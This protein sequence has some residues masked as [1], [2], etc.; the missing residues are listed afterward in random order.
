MTT[1]QGKRN[2]Q[3]W[4]STLCVCEGRYCSGA[5]ALE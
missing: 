2:G 4:A 3:G 1:V 5:A